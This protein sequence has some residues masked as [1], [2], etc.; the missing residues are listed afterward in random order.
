M[1]SENF[2]QTSPKAEFC[3]IFLTLDDQLITF[4]L[5]AMVLR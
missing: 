5:L 3:Y 4:I 2:R 1:I